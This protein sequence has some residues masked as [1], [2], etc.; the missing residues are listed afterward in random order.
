MTRALNFKVIFKNEINWT[1]P[2]RFYPDMLI[3]EF[4]E[5]S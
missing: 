4:S 5:G 1:L 2:D 3:S